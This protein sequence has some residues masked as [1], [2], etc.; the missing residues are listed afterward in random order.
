MTEREQDKV[1]TALAELV[2]WY[3]EENLGEYCKRLERAR[4]VIRRAGPEQLKA[5]VEKVHR[6]SEG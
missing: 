2:A 1:L 6:K 5:E 3:G 4:R